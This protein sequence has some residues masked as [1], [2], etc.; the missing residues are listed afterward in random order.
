METLVWKFFLCVVLVG[1]GLPVTKRCLDLVGLDERETP[2][3][4]CVAGNQTS[5][6]RDVEYNISKSWRIVE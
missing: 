6:D 4:V 2:M 3:L 5:N 1:G